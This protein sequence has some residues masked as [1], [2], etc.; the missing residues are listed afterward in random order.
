MFKDCVSLTEL[1]LLQS[2]QAIDFFAFENSGITK[3]DLSTTKIIKQ[4]AFANSNI[5]EIILNNKIMTDKNSEGLEKVNNYKGLSD[6]NNY[7]DEHFCVYSTLFWNS[8]IT[9]VTF[10]NDLDSFSLKYF[11]NLTIT[12]INCNGNPNFKFEDGILYNSD[13]SKIIAFLKHDSTSFTIPEN[14]N[15]IQPFAFAYSKLTSLT[16]PRRIASVD[17]IF[18]FCHELTE[19]TF[20]G[21][22]TKLG[23]DT[24][25]HCYK[26]E[27][28]NF[29]R[30]SNLVYIGSYCFCC[31]YS[32]YN[33]PSFNEVLTV[34]SFSFAYCSKLTTI[35]LPNAYEIDVFSFWNSGL[36]SITADNLRLIK[37][38][39]FNGTMIK[40]Y[41]CPNELRSIEKCA[42][43]NCIQLTKFEFNDKIE[44]IN[45][46]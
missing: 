46:Y 9:K 42:F 2:I 4:F 32:L 3:I 20:E 28:I 31:C 17:G 27:K 25:S 19:V 29:N 1:I 6:N 11:P 36:E 23:N 41:K 40:E 7:P 10:G 38:N 35:N 45:S 15:E 21:L 39:A 26:L 30:G 43:S 24:F 14:V 44:A 34:S 13:K 18:A 33:F 22:I 8:K 12:E 5:N 37:A 16:I